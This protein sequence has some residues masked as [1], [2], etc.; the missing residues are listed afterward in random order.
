[1]KKNLP[2][3][4]IAISVLLI[5]VIIIVALSF[6]K[7]QNSGNKET[8]ILSEN[9]LIKDK[10]VIYSNSTHEVN[11]IIP[12]FQNIEGD[13]GSYIN[14]KIYNDLSDNK[15]YQEAIE[16]YENETPGFFTYETN[17]ER[18]NCGK[19][20]S[21]VVN[22]YIHLGY[23]RPR[24]QKKCYVLDVSRNASPVL[25]DLFEDKINYKKVI[26]D[27]IN[28]QAAKE[29]IEL[30]GGNGLKELSELQSFYIKDN[31]LILYFEASEIAATAVGE[32]EFTMPFEMV[33]GKFIIKN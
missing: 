11:L 32:L 3:I 30:I 16:G 29:N 2:K 15:V 10:K 33:D 14:S 18:Y 1:M 8:E 5:V 23:G 4:C 25:M 22:Q 24:V 20:L 7:T 19:Y 31:Q 17:Y 6:N 26:I 13:Y 9:I 21:V 28:Q 12:E 27:E